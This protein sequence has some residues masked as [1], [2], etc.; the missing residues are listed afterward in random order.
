[1]DLSW[2]LG[3]ARVAF[4]HS[5][6]PVSLTTKAGT[7]T[8]LEAI[9][10][11]VTPPCNLNPL[12][13]NGHL[14]TAWTAVKAEGPPII[15]KRKIFESE[16][17]RFAGAFTVDF[18]QHTPAKEVD[19]S[20]PPRTT[21]FTDS[22]Y[23]GLEKGSDDR[24]PMLISLHGLSGGSHEIYLRQVLA[25]LVEQTGAGGA[26]WE[27]VVVNSR[28][29]ANSDITTGILYNARATW[30]MRQMVRWCRA[31]YPNRPLYAIG[32][33]LGANILTNY[34][35]E[36]GENCMLNAA[37]VVA[38]PWKLEVASLAMQRTWLGLNVYSRTM[39]NSMKKLFER[40]AK[41]IMTN[42]NIDPERVRKITYLHEFDREIQG[43]TWG[44]P[45]EGAYYR[46]AS[47]VDSILNIRIPVF[48][49]NAEDDPI[50]VHEAIPYEEI[51]QNPYTVMCTTS[52]GGHLSWFEIGGS[53][54]FSKPVI[55]LT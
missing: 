34:L 4:H 31:K 21:Y 25:P 38:N 28:G 43:P 48:A 53:R 30:D 9:C 2:I 39:G 6:N 16:D 11:E 52:M 47:S 55:F 23:A 18:V 33:S 7:K 19:E 46:D 42:G 14:Q 1:M 51:K 12:L 41:M 37:V 35:G 17:P 44:Y 15:Y 5:K 13:F 26:E 27:A 32:Y 24:K 50:A 8:T 54:W 45:T 29:C 3:R 49:I 20:L 10:K 40:H 36:E 22:E